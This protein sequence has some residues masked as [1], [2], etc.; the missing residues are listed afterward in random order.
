MAVVVLLAAIWAAVLVPPAV[1]S[2]RARRKAFEISFG[3]G[4]SP[5]VAPAVA[6]HARHSP[7][8]QR[9][10]R[11]A[12]GLLTAVVA[13]GVVGLLPTFRVLLVVHLF[14]VDSFLFYVASLARRAD[15]QARGSRAAPGP[16]PVPEPAFA[17]PS[18]RRDRSV[19]RPV[20]LADV[21]PVA[22]AG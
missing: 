7:A 15:R 16:A 6:A 5:A 14:V 9:R 21:L 10:R 18:R 13:T 22:S 4:P 20:A 19:P 11:I 17:P 3:R 2:Q 1:R 12:G 8:V